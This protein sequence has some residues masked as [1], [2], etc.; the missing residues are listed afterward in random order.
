MTNEPRAGDTFAG[1]VIEAEV[2]RGGMGIVFRARNI[3]LDRVRAVKVVAPALSADPAFAARFRREARLAASVE[4][5]NVVTVHHA[6]EEDGLLYIVMRYVD[7]TDL[8]RVIADGALPPDRAL[9]ILRP[10]ASALDAA[11]AGGLVHRDVKPANVLIE[12]PIDGD[13]ERVYLTDFGI[14]KPLSGTGPGA[15]ET[16]AALT[17]AGQVLGTADY[18]S[19]EAVEGEAID[20]RSD[21]YSFACLAYH[22]L[23]GR[24]PFQRSSELA[25]LVAHTK[26]PRPSASD[27]NPALPAGA[28]ASLRDGMAIDPA[29]RPP[30]AKALVDRLERELTGS[31]RRPRATSPRSRRT[32]ALIALGSALAAGVAVGAALLLAGGDDGAP[33]EPA[34][35]VVLT[36]P[37]GAG[38][39]GLAVGEVRIWVASRDAT[40]DGEDALGAI[41]RLRRAAPVEAKDPVPLP[42]PRSVA[43]GFG[44]IWVVNGEALYRLDP[45]ESKPA[46]PIEVGGGPGD[47]AVDGRYVWVVN[48]DED[49]VTRVEPF[50]PVDAVTVPVGKDPRAIATGSGDVW[51]ANAGDGTVSRIS[52]SE[53]EVTTTVE[54]GPR[55]TSIAVGTKSVWV[56]DNAESTLTEISRDSFEAGTP[57]P[58]AAQPR[59]VAVGLGYVWVASGAESVVES[60]DPA[61]GSRVGEPIAVGTEPA[62][63]AVGSAAVYTANFG[64]GTVSRIEPGN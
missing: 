9:A 33:V 37:V 34:E 12:H 5:P 52:S 7:G 45:G 48:E 63:V 42:T 22:L 47:V 4:H 35:T 56:A 41:Y 28:A 36:E 49:T 8:A 18:V 39:V 40:V 1:H 43:V 54:V 2:G 59:G 26:A 15:D 25:T 44:S 21:I 61:D 10:A 19:P 24:P 57:I 17:G 23:A 51:V 13:A 50:D 38:P 31:V 30:S 20:A 60:F 11:H 14:S 27:A 55:P 3:A 46:L 29:Q 6:G 16:T 53:A 32:P 64:N 62:D 58:V